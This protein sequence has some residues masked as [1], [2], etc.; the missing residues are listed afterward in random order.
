MQQTEIDE[1]E[2]KKL[3]DELNKREEAQKKEKSKKSKLLKKIK[4]M[5]EKLVHGSEAMEQAMKQ[6]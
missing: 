6:E 5:E 1:E 4:G 3:M 2:K